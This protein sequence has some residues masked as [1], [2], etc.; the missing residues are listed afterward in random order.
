[1]K[2]M[3][4][5]P[6]DRDDEYARIRKSGW[7]YIDDESELS[8]DSFVDELNKDDAIRLKVSKK[9][10]LDSIFEM[11]VE[12]NE[13]DNV[14]SQELDERIRQ[15][16]QS[17]RDS[18]Q[19]WTIYI[20]LDGIVLKGLDSIEVGR[21]IIHSNASKSSLLRSQ[22]LDSVDSKDAADEAKLNCELI[23]QRCYDDAFLSD[24]S[25]AEVVIE[26]EQSRAHELAAY[27]I[28]M[29]LNLLRCYTS[30]I[31]S[32]DL[33][34]KM[35]LPESA[36]SGVRICVMLES[37]KN[38]Y[39][40]ES[41][42]VNTAGT[43]DLSES[44]I[45]HLR[46]YCAFNE[47]CEALKKNSPDRSELENVLVT[48]IRWLGQGVASSEQPEKVLCYAIALER[49]MT[50]DNEEHID[51]SDR[52]ARRLAFLL[53]DTYDRRY[54][55]WILAKRLYGLRSKVAHA[56]R[57]DFATNDIKLLER[58]A[59]SAL[60]KLGLHLSEWDTHQDFINWTRQQEFS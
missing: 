30:V 18:L 8:L 45:L 17:L 7:I 22:M 49:M 51:I 40:I 35:S 42:Y 54:E 34:P 10:V 3:E 50:S 14:S 13:K 16:I 2:D 15:L 53:G 56:G 25:L 9:H 46:D 60:I 27:E 52:L 12:L 37:E 26:A 21:T 36:E 59:L 28:E 20:P 47:L 38:E 1:M 29:A 41:R 55:I 33:R 43:Y 58:Y 44:N 32:G 31:H 11:L 4:T 19:K 5:S 24:N 39:R 57:T 6:I 48:A 23:I